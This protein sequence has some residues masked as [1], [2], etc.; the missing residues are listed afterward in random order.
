M[1]RMNVT[2]ERITAE[3]ILR[4]GYIAEGHSFFCELVKLY[5]Y[6]IRNNISFYHMVCYWGFDILY[7]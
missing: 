6:C 1:K 2:D 3:S 7:E 4:A 5:G